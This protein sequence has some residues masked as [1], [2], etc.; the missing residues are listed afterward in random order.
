MMLTL[1]TDMTATAIKISISVMPRSSE[2]IRLLPAVVP[3]VIAH[4]L[5]NSLP[6]RA[7][8]DSH[9]RP[10]PSADIRGLTG[11]GSG[12]HRFLMP[13]PAMPGSDHNR[14]WS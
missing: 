3:M 8:P 7:F 10:P 1:I 2:C 14:F 9:V 5:S 13:R 12:P 6:G 11:V 4:H